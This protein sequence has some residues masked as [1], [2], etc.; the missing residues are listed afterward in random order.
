M[1]TSKH[2]SNPNSYFIPPEE[3][4]R[5]VTAGRVIEDRPHVIT[6]RYED[7]VRD[8]V[9]AL[10]R[11]CEF[12]G[13]PFTKEAFEA[14]PNSAQLQESRAWYG[15]ARRISARSVGRWKKDEH[16][17]VVRRLYATEGAEELLSYYGYLST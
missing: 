15:Q 2:P 1:V 8:Y 11:I 13:E 12:I 6:M 9:P 10:Q 16:S 5:D 3:W 14:Y 7:I 4:V 17:E